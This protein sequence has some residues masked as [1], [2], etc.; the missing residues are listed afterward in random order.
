MPNFEY[1]GRDSS[2]G[3][4]TGT[5]DAGNADEVAT[6][7]FG[8]NVTP[9]DIKQVARKRA[10]T[11][12]RAGAE[13]RST[14]EN[15][16]AILAK[17]RV[18]TDDLIMFARQMHSLTKAGLPLDRAMKGLEASLS[19]PLFKSVLQDV[20]DGLE[21]GQSLAT[22]MGGHPKT[23]SDLFLSLIHVGENTGRLDLAFQEIGRYLE[24]EKNTRKQVK[25]A[26]RY[27]MFV[28]AAM[29]AAL[30]VITVFVIPVFSQTFDRLGAELPWQT[31]VLINT[32]DFVVN[33]WPFLLGTAVVSF[34][35]FRYWVNTEKGRL[36][37]DRRKMRFP[38]AGP[39]FEKVALGRFS[40]T[41]AMV[42]KA[43]LPI[44]QGLNVVAG[45]V[46]NAYVSRNVTR[47]R[48]SVERGESLQRTAV[49]SKMFTPLV[50]QMISV[51]EETGAVD[52]L[53]AEVAEFYDAEVEYDL[54]QMSDA[55]EPILISFIAGL[56]LILALGV[57][58]PI[59]D[60]N[61]A[62]RQ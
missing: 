38:L 33:Y 10:T 52:E 37:W 25:S 59:W 39:V 32:S 18:E 3:L 1:S 49:N 22:A 42:L 60:L 8:Q 6:Q 28:I 50:L 2:G 43:G 46:G 19:N 12:K 57:F 34:F 53:L 47:M 54:K 61:T 36:S 4:V 48:E 27:P 7:L 15:I 51:G 5:I 24:L 29:I 45:A 58:L 55:I 26:T 11:K 40:R 35:W 17:N 16:N 9:V 56:V 21:N 20:I 62:V 14:I 31:V 13:S 44:V 30:A 23:F 41:L